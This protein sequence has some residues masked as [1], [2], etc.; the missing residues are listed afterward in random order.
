MGRTTSDTQSYTIQ[1]VNQGPSAALS[2]T[3]AVLRNELV[4]LSAG[5]SEDP[6]GLPLYYQF[7]TTNGS[8]TFSQSYGSSSLFSF[9][10]TQL[11][12]YTTTVTV[13]DSGDATA[14]A[15]FS[16]IVSASI[17]PNI[18]SAGGYGFEV[19]NA[20]GHT[21]VRNDELMIR[22]VKRVVLDANGN[23]TTTVT[24]PTPDSKV[25]ATGA[26]GTGTL[27]NIKVQTTVSGST[28]TVTL[29]SFE[30]SYGQAD[31]YIIK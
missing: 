21:V 30:S 19:Y 24:L 20:L 12:V 18:G 17:A 29:E 16:T 4:E 14:T 26:S 27:G 23:A 28:A 15:L 3:Q 7:S 2:G 9:T 10:P 1:F 22:K 6:D 31:L 8:Q 25:M 11:G 5:A 13:R